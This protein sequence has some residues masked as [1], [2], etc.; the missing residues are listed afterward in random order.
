[1]RVDLILGGTGNFH[2][3]NSLSVLG[4][5]DWKLTT[6]WKVR[7]CWKSKGKKAFSGKTKDIF[8][9]VGKFWNLKFLWV[10]SQ[11]WELELWFELGVG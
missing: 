2:G 7:A 4:S 6:V 3:L 1:M 9:K 8:L 5:E 10:K 11:R